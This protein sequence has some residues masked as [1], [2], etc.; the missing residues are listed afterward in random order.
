MRRKRKRATS[1]IVDGI[2][3]NIDDMKQASAFDNRTT[4]QVQPRHLSRAWRK[5]DKA[6]RL[7]DRT[8]LVRLACEMRIW[9]W[10]KALRTH[11]RVTCMTCLV[12]MSRTDF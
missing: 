3:H 7:Q 6:Q 10:H 12:V 4:G 8:N 2:V 5:I 1:V 11:A 9:R